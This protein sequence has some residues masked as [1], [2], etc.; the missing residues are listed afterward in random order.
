[1][2]CSWCWA[3]LCAGFSGRTWWDRSSPEDPCPV[4]ASKRASLCVT[5]TCTGLN[6][7]VAIRSLWDVSDTNPAW[8]C[9]MKLLS[10]LGSLQGPW[11]TNWASKKQVGTGQA[12]TLLLG[13]NNLSPLS[14]CCLDYSLKG[15]LSRTSS[16]ISVTSSTHCSIW[17]TEEPGSSSKEI[18][19]LLLEVLSVPKRSQGQTQPWKVSSETSPSPSPMLHPQFFPKTL[20]GWLC[21]EQAVC[22]AGRLHAVGAINHS[23]GCAVAHAENRGTYWQ[24]CPHINASTPKRAPKVKTT[25]CFIKLSPL[26]AKIANNRQS[27]GLMAWYGT[28]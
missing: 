11:V 18:N 20:P 15:K 4:G 27:C 14:V 12:P 9:W 24:G 16:Q 10:P 8:D 25:T 6:F 26:W 23:V 19:K 1:M 22:W 13:W 17:V 28:R 21:Q 5:I 3:G 7:T 2:I